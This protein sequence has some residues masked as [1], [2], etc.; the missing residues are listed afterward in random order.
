MSTPETRSIGALAVHL[1]VVA[2]AGCRE[3]PNKAGGAS[4]QTVVLTLA[5]HEPGTLP[6][7]VPLIGKPCKRRAFV[8]QSG[9]GN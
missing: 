1:L 7:P 6:N 9:N 2:S 5:N 8:S 3:S 4:H